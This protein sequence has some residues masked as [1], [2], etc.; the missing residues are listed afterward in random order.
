MTG[1]GPPFHRVTRSEQSLPIFASGRLVRALLIFA[2]H[3]R[4]DDPFAVDRR[5]LPSMATGAPAHEASH[6]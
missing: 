3:Q 5:W 6:G 2:M 4:R 1:Y